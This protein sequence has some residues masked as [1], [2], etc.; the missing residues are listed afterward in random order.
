MPMR[1]ENKPELA[2]KINASYKFEVT[3]DEQ[4]SWIVDLTSAPG[5][6]RESNDDADCTI[7]VSGGDLVD[8]VVGKLN[9]QMAFM[10][11]KLKVSGDMALAMKLGTLLA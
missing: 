10:E 2:G 6:V 8:I 4:S 9:G 5:V 11:G 7:T 1:L 3:G